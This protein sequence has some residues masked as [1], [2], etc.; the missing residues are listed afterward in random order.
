MEALD[1][2][3]PPAR[4]EVKAWADLIHRKEKACRRARQCLQAF[5]VSLALGVFL[6]T[7][8]KFAGEDWRVFWGGVFGTIVAV[9]VVILLYRGRAFSKWL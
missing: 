3:F 1:P 6:A 5:A 8:N 9:E 4:G 2:A 7:W